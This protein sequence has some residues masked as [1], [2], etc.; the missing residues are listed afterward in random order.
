MEQLSELEKVIFNKHL[1]VSRSIKNKPFKIRKDFSSVAS[2][3][4][5][6]FLKRI[7]NLIR[8]HPEIDVNTFFEAPY[9]LYP[10]VEYFGLDYF[11]SMR[12]VKAYATYKKQIFLQDPDSQL[13]SVKESLKFITRFCIENKILLH[14]YPNHSSSDVFTWMT[15]YKQNKINIYVMMEFKDIYSAVQTLAEDVRRFYVSEF[16]EQFKHLR[17]MYTSSKELQ[18]YLKKALPLVNNFIHSELSKTQTNV[19]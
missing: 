18:Q 15:H 16:V 1:A 17:S 11:S 3:D 10:D 8:K 6:K 4:K 14:Q 9:R 5:H 2:S 12:A 19:I 7:S 13:E